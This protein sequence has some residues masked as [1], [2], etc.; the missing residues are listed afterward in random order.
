MARI[1]LCKTRFVPKALVGRGRPK[2]TK[3]QLKQKVVKKHKLK[4][5]KKKAKTKKKHKSKPHGSR[6]NRK[7][8]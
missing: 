4:K 2:N 1:G 8:S 6:Q 3:T 7:S 5:P